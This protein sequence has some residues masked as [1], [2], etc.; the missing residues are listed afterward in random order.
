LSYLLIATQS[1][2]DELFDDI[3]AGPIAFSDV[4]PSTAQIR[5]DVATAG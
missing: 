1:E 3:E 5:P 2:D 4:V